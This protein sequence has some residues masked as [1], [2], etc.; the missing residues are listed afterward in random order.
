MLLCVYNAEL[1]W[2]IVYILIMLHAAVILLK[3]YR[4]QYNFFGE[5]TLRLWTCR[6]KRKFQLLKVNWITTLLKTLIMDRVEH[7]F[8]FTF[9]NSESKLVKYNFPNFLT[10]FK[11]QVWS[12]KYFYQVYV[13]SI[14][15]TSVFSAVINIILLIKHFFFL[16]WNFF[17]SCITSKN[18]KLCLSVPH[19]SHYSFHSF[20]SLTKGRMEE[21][22][23]QGKVKI[24]Y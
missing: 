6:L 3:S 10:N 9:N 21:K 18:Y 1:S 5:I 14:M 20:C 2:N 4:I 17:H 12:I 7:N 23:Y 19:T 15:Q 16:A 13:I 22:L 11:T 24:S 8:W